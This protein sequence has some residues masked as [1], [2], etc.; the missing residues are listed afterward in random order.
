VKIVTVISTILTTACSMQAVPPTWEELSSRLFTNSIIVWQA[1]TNHLPESFWIYKRNLPDI[2]SATIISNAIV[3]GSLQSKGFPKPSTNQTCIVAEPPS[4]CCNVCNFF[5]NPSDAA[6]N[7]ESPDYKNGSPEG[8]PDDETIVRRAWDYVPQLG[9]DSKHL[10]PKTF[11]THF[12]NADTSG[13]ETTNFI[14]GR[15]VFLSRELDRIIFFSADDTGDGAEGFSIEFGSNGQVRFFSLRWSDM[16][17]YEIQ[18]IA[19]IQEIINCIKAHKAIVL[20]KPDEED[21]FARLKKL[22]TAKKLT[23]TKITP[24]YGEGL[25]G[26]APT[27]DVPFGFAMPFA[28][29]EAIADFGNSNSAVRLVSPITSSEVKRVMMKK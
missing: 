19:S 16:T 2:F 3:L 22:A 12:Y 18:P 21:F 15:G 7:F 17:R 23:I 4:P 26:E 20:P 5:I 8:I 25:F 28:E 9:L 10:T 1:P 11:F 14:C 13:K 27:N 6:L 24:F 29:L